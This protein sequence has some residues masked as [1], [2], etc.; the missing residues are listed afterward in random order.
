MAVLG[1]DVTEKAAGVLR[2]SDSQEPE[3]R[4]G[5]AN[6]GGIQTGFG[7]DVH[8]DEHLLMKMLLLYM[9]CV[10]IYIYIIYIHCIECA[11]TL[12]NIHMLYKIYSV[13]MYIYTHY[14]MCMC[15]IKYIHFIYNI[16]TYIQG[17][18]V[19]TQTLL[20][21]PEEEPTLYRRLRKEV[22]CACVC[23]CVCVCTRARAVC[24]VLSSIRLFT[25]SCISCTGI[26]VLYH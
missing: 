9:N 24:S 19:L 17:L 18:P 5:W 4:W 1:D 8:T 23:V 16:C 14:I 6:Q 7:T 10:C 3:G 12:Y 15:Y 25:T 22:A 11:Y 20:F 21:V 26:W 2:W 13:Y